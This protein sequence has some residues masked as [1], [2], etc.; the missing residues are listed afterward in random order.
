MFK[1]NVVPAIIIAIGLVAAG[2]LSGGRYEIA[3]QSGADFL[4]LDRW[5]GNVNGCS[6]QSEFCSRYVD[7]FGG[8]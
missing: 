8:R 6:M 1:G 7:H 4:L 3:Q 5:T 2:F